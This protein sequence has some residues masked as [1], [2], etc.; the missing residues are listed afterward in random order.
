M[1]Y[2]RGRSREPAP[3]L[4]PRLG[5]RGADVDRGLLS[6]DSCVSGGA[7]RLAEL[8]YPLLFRRRSTHWRTLARFLDDPGRDGHQPLSPECHG[9]DF[10][11]YAVRHGPGRLPSFSPHWQT[12]PL[13]HALDRNHCLRRD[14][15][16]S[17]GAL[18]R[19]TDHHLQLAARRDHG[20]DGP[21]C[22]AASSEASRPAALVRNSGWLG[23]TNCR[24]CRGNPH[25][26]GRPTRER[27]LWTAL[28]TSGSGGG[29]AGLLGAEEESEKSSGPTSR[30]RLRISRCL[31]VSMVNRFLVLAH[32]VQEFV[33]RSRKRQEPGASV[34]Q[35][36]GSSRKRD[37]LERVFRA[38]SRNLPPH[39][40][41]LVG[42]H[43]NSVP[44]VS[45]RIVHAVHLPGM[46]HEVE[47]EV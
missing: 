30:V 17:G 12:P 19:A 11:P 43:C 31:C 10:H 8:A 41:P 16:P 37:P 1:L 4:P 42:G 7:G 20:V 28:E 27:S 15:W 47:S 9:P 45:Q 24:R 35:A 32:P 25:E 40:L 2:S 23:W 33:I 13:R 29:T 3:Q 21:C 34:I 14:L 39:Q 6:A 18:P 5:Y 44:G 22:L 46:R 38:F 26:R 36:E